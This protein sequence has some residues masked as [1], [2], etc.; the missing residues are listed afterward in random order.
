MFLLD[1]RNLQTVLIGQILQLGSC[2]LQIKAPNSI[3]ASTKSEFLFEENNFFL[4][5][6]IIFSK[7]I[8]FSC[9]FRILEKTLFTLPSIAIVG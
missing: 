9:L 4:F 6:L 5:L 8:F 3:M 7:F 2:G 1:L